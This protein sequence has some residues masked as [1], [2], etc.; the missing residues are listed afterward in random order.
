MDSPRKN[1]MLLVAFGLL[2]AGFNNHQQ[3]M[4]LPKMAVDP[5]CVV[6]KTDFLDHLKQ[7]KLVV[8]LDFDIKERRDDFLKWVQLSDYLAAQLSM[9]T[10]VYI[11]LSDCNTKYLNFLRHYSATHDHHFILMDNGKEFLKANDI[12][13]AGTFSVLLDHRNHTILS[14]KK[15]FSPAVQQQYISKVEQVLE[16]DLPFVDTWDSP[17]V[18]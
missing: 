6:D 8:F 18:E 9:N 10:L 1:I 15:S 12:K 13:P 7:D 14:S 16:I 17:I 2:L 5:Y 4:I 3:K 11:H